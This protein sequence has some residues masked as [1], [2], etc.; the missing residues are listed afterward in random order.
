MEHKGYS[1]KGIR[2]PADFRWCTPVMNFQ[3]MVN[4]VAAV[5]VVAMMVSMTDWILRSAR[6]CLALVVP[7]VFNPIVQDYDCLSLTSKVAH[8]P[9]LPQ[10]LIHLPAIMHKTPK[11]QSSSKNWKIIFNIINVLLS[12]STF[13]NKNPY[14]RQSDTSFSLLGVIEN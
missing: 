5:T 3:W 4:S 12:N 14:S 8:T 11:Q 2:R 9:S 1:N 7:S 13:R 10:I 6:I